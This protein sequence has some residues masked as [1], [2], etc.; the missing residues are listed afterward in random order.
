MSTSKTRSPNKPLVVVVGATAVG[1]SELALRAAEALRG[2]IVSAD[3]RQFYRM[4]DIGTAKPTPDERARVPHHLIDVA[5]PDE[6]W[7]LAVFQA[8]AAAAIEDIHRRGRLPFLVGGTGQYV[9]AVCEGWQP[10]SQPPDPRLRQALDAWAEAIGAYELHRRLAVVDPVAAEQID[11]RNVRRSVR[12]LEVILH[13]GRRFSAQR[14]KQPGPYDLLKIGL[15]RPRAELYARVDA[16]IE[17]MIG[18]GLV[19]EV[20]GLLARGYAPELPTMSAI[21]YRQI[22][23][24]LRGEISLEEALAHMKRLTR[25]YVRQQGAW[26]RE[27]DASI[28]WFQPGAATQAEVVRLI[29]GWLA[30]EAAG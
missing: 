8:R 23:A 25:R 22:A 4:M 10:P 26:F 11:P 7:S 12:A 9:Q 24:Y 17:A 15:T 16:R 27:E 28:H 30:G 29:R 20:R 6:S 13:S 5:D 2:E 3:S 19:E 14:Q 18:G 21:G 1:K